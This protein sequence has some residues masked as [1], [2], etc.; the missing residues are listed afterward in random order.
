VKPVLTAPPPNGD[1][2]INFIDEIHTLIGE[3]FS[4]TCNKFG[5]T[6]GQR[7]RRGWR[8]EYVEHTKIRMKWK[9]RKPG[10]T[11]ERN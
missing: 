7:R 8:R 1:H 3:L 2:S 5:I 6:L 9:G 10:K 4:N 11:G